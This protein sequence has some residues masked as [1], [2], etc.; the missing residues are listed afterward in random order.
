MDVKKDVNM[1]VELDVHMD[2]EMDVH[3]DVKLDVIIGLGFTYEN[4][5]LLPYYKLGASKNRGLGF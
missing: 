2:V 5:R 3:M 1:D 4:Y